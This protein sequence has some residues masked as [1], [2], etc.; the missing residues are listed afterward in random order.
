MKEGKFGMDY[1]GTVAVGKGGGI[2]KM[3]PSSSS[4]YAKRDEIGSGPHNY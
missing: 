2:C 4:Y 1:R 3:W